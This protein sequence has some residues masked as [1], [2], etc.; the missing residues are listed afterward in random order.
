MHCWLKIRKRIVVGIKA[1]QH[2]RDNA[3]RLSEFSNCS[4]GQFCD[5]DVS[6]W[7]LDWGPKSKTHARMIYFINIIRDKVEITD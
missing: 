3:I 6:D 1:I 7:M 5:S 2:L 4:L